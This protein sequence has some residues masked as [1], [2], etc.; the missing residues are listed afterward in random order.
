MYI[1]LAAA[2]TVN[3]VIVDACHQVGEII[4]LNLFYGRVGVLW[5][6]TKTRFHH[7]HLTLTK[8]HLATIKNM[9]DQDFYNRC[10]DAH[11]T[12]VYRGHH[13]QHCCF[14]FLNIIQIPAV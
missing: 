8:L 9:S 11:T 10:V 6:S 13:N 12:F 1:S 5:Y 4:N 14:I 7:C 3:V 2:V